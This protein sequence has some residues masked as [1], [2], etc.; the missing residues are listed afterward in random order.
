[1]STCTIQT[2]LQHLHTPADL[3]LVTHA[4]YGESS[5][6]RHGWMRR[7]IIGRLC[8]LVYWDD[9]GWTYATLPGSTLS[10]ES[11]KLVALTVKCSWSLVDVEME[12]MPA[13]HYREVVV[14][15]DTCS[16]HHGLNVHVKSICTAGHQEVVLRPEDFAFFLRL[17]FFLRSLPSL[18]FPVWSNNETARLQVAL[19]QATIQRS[20]V[21]YF[22][23]CLN[24]CFY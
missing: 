2:P 3:L 8:P 14:A 9:R 22:S 5:Q 10:R 15:T 18:R 20:R 6:L 17:L 21:R 24:A 23:W 13:D 19:G 11:R 7:V 4:L 12:G 1:M 16:R